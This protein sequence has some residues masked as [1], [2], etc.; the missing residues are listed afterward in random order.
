V[1]ELPEPVARALLIGLGV[2]LGLA[3]ASC[4]RGVASPTPTGSPVPL[5]PSPHLAPA[6]AERLFAEAGGFLVVE[7]S[8]EGITLTCTVVEG[9]FCWFGEN[10]ESGG[11]PRELARQ[12]I[13]ELGGL[14]VEQ[15]NRDE[16]AIR[17][18]R[19]VGETAAITC[20][21]DW[22]WGGGWE[23]VPLE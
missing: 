18:S 3:L 12:V 1:Q 17:C 8:R 2:A 5:H 20:E 7:S 4:V 19:P 16:V 6:T 15:A 14:A 22:G 13:D 11:L 10:V 9:T 23:P 21:A